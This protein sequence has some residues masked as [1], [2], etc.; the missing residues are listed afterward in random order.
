MKKEGQFLAVRAFA[1][2][3]TGR[4]E[5][6]LDA[7]HRIHD[8]FDLAAGVIHAADDDAFL[9]A[10]GNDQL[11]VDQKAQIA[12]LEPAVVPE[13]AIGLGIAEIS[14]G[15]HR[16]GNLQ[17]T[18]CLLGNDFVVIVHDPNADPRN[19]RTQ[20]RQRGCLVFLGDA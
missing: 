9:G 4:R 10:A 20:S 6:G 15:N 13:D 14:R 19:G 5:A 16:T 11:A 17:M 2:D 1:T 3:G 12:R 18:Q 8:L 7:G